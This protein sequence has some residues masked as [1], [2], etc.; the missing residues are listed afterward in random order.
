MPL[1][2][3][4]IFQKLGSAIK[5]IGSKLAMSPL[6]C[7]PGQQHQFFAASP[8]IAEFEG[9]RHGWMVAQMDYRRVAGGDGFSQAISEWAGFSR[10]ARKTSRRLG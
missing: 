5:N 6:K 9:I 4:R 1:D 10:A 7:L 3:S 8:E 2:Q